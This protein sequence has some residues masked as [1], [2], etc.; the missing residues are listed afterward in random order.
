SVARPLS[1]DAP[2][3][4]PEY[5]ERLLSCIKT[6]DDV[7]ALWERLREVDPESAEKIHKNNVKRVIRALEIYE[8]TGK[9]KSLLDK[10]SKAERGEIYVGMITIDF[11]SRELLYER[12]D[13]R[14]DIMMDEGL[15]D[16]V[17]SLYEAD[18]IS[19]GTASAAIGYKE[20]IDHLEGRCTLEEAV[21]NIKLASRRYAKRQLTWFRHESDAK[22][23]YADRPDGKIKSADDMLDE[24]LALAEEMMRE[25]KSMKGDE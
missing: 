16:E 12:V 1:Q 25:F 11:H 3:S 9:P 22:V 17:R 19:G 8:K 7:T 13:R 24:A 5:R 14:V 6:D 23:I 15:L 10:E 21:S 2:E 4:D 20:L 18:L